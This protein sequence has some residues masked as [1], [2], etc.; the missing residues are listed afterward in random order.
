M[1]F[2]TYLNRCVY[3]MSFIHTIKS[4]HTLRNAQSDLGLI[5]AYM[6]EGTFS[7]VAAYLFDI[8][9]LV[10]LNKFRFHTHF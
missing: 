8:L 9:T 3:V 1:K 2:S 6:L 10:L 5:L 7:H 4:D